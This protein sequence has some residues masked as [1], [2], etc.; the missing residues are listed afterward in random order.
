MSETKYNLPNNKPSTK[1]KSKRDFSSDS[2]N[3]DGMDEKELCDYDEM[4]DLPLDCNENTCIICD[5][6]GKDGEELR[7]VNS[8]PL[9]WC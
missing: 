9:Q 5:E 1:P 2:E 7:F 8:R 3:E 4:D 6:F